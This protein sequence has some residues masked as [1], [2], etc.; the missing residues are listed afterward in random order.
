[1]RT[2]CKRR[3][4]I[5]DANDAVADIFVTAWRKIDDIPQGHEARL[6]MYGVARNAVRN[7]ERGS[8]RRVRLAAKAGTIAPNPPPGPEEVVVRRAEDRLIVDAMSSLKPDDQE[9]LRLHLW[10][11]LPHAETGRVLGISADAARVRIA[12]AIKRMTRALKSAPTINVPTRPRA[13]EEEG[14]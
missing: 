3:L 1:M 8:R 9:A 5:Q 13:A 2:Y 6:W 11:E 10:E 12:R 7:T 4:N 14:G